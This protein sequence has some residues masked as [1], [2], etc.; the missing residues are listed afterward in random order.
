LG[1][2]PAASRAAELG[3]ANACQA[4]AIRAELDGRA[5]FYSGDVNAF[6][7]IR[8][9]MAGWFHRIDN[10]RRLYTDEPDLTFTGMAAAPIRHLT[11]DTLREEL[12]F[13]P[14]FVSL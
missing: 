1:T 4:F 9:A 14:H 6:E 13:G 11:E 12:D 8:Q 10:V 7:D 2:S 3:Y 5:L